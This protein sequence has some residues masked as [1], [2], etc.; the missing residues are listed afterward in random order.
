MA[1]K[2][3][4]SRYKASITIY[5][6]ISLSS[7]INSIASRIAFTLT[8]SSAAIAIGLLVSYYGSLQQ[9]RKSDSVEGYRSQAPILL[10]QKNLQKKN[11]KFLLTTCNISS[12]VLYLVQG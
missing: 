12:A 8:L 5:I 6:L 10:T 11:K 1:I 9:T 4:T 2:S 7:I 3:Y